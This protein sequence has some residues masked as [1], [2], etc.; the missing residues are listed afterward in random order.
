MV[1]VE[2]LRS[3]L[4]VALGRLGAS[5][6]EAAAQAEQ[7]VEAELRGRPSHGLHRLAVLAERVD[8]GL[9]QPGAE[10]D[11][12]WKTS[13]VLT[14]NGNGGFGPHVAGVALALLAE[15][16]ASTGICLGAV[17]NAGHL[18]MLGTYMEK[19]AARGLIGI[20]MTTSEALVH[21]SGGVSAMVGTNPIAVGIPAD[22]DPPFVLDMSTSA[23][24]MG[25]VIASIHSNQ[26][27]P[28]GVAVDSEGRPTTDPRAAR[29]GAISPFGG[30]KGY[31]L[32][33][34]IELLVASLSGTAF[35]TDVHGTLDAIHPVSKG[36][37][38]IV[39]DPE[40]FDLA[41][42]LVDARDYLRELRSS[43]PAPGT[44]GVSVPGDRAREE[45]E[46]RISDGIPVVESVWK[47]AREL[48]EQPLNSGAERV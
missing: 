5:D 8:R 26:R 28:E 38:F 36:D 48:A 37:I 20:A 34:A 40:P 43:P 29:E 23:I 41:R 15:R 18:G 39:I 17:R 44:G 24:S 6:A 32:A 47:R 42:A 33:L 12:V 13:A 4:S 16:A 1:S 35:G 31:G 3:T 45:R 2:Q 11:A 10:V 14:V 27:L 22:S 21:P 19:V 46:R 30:G 9:L 25:E 7:L